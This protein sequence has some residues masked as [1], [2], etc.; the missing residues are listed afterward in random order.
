MRRYPHKQ[1][2]SSPG[3]K[4]R[5]WRHDPT[6]VGLSSGV[7]MNSGSEQRR[8]A[9]ALRC[10]PTATR[11]ARDAPGTLARRERRLGLAAP[12]RLVPPGGRRARRPRC[13]SAGDTVGRRAGARPRPGLRRRRHRRDDRRPRR[14]LYRTL[15]ATE[16]PMPVLRALCEGWADAQAGAVVVRHRARPRVGPA[17]PAVPGA[18]AR[19]DVPRRGAA[20]RSA[21]APS[22]DLGH[23]LVLVD[24]ATG[25][26]DPF[27]RAA[28]S[29][30]VGAAMTTTYGDGPP[31]G[32]ARRWRVR[33]ARARRRGP[34]PAARGAARARSTAAASC[35]RSVPSRAS[36][37]ACGSSR[38]PT[39]HEQALRM[40][41]RVAR[42]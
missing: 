14:C 9:G 42:P 30:A 1:G 25:D 6:G 23:H 33:R 34:A 29:A 21:P 19:G 3:E 7:T 41:E 5:E 24:V 17:E 37:S 39:T 20:R 26:V 22:A 13:S 35:S 15:G 31:D 2:E 8:R 32:D 40:L 27:T 28:R 11:A 16:P 38:C 18:P 4:A 12:V 36:P 10:V